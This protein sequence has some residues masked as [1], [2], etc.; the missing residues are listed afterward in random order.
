MD[1]WVW[2]QNKGYLLHFD[3]TSFSSSLRLSAADV[4]LEAI[5]LKA[6]KK[7]DAWLTRSHLI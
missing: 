4:N 6:E 2:G 3:G 7:T 5:F 1:F